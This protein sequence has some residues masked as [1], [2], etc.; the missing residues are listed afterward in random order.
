ME[1]L[2]KLLNEACIYRMSDESMDSFMGL[3]TEVELKNNE[4]LIPYGKFDDNIYVLKEGIMR[5][6]YFD[7]LKEMTFGFSSPG[8][9][10][11]QYHSFYKREPSFFQV[12]SCGRST[13]MKVSRADFERLAKSSSDFLNWMFRIS[14]LQLW[15]N[16]RKLAVLNGTA[17]E[18]FEALIR[19]RPDILK[20]VSSK[21]IASY[22]GVT[23][24][25]FSRLKRE[26]TIAEKSEKK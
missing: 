11:I 24:S 13:V 7:G 4:P 1:E 14:S 19:I 12:E 6:A 16:E 9:V 20:T 17:K 5:F 18:R 3:M 22:I 10:I 2:R 21:V 26:L 25:S 8:T 23:P 15:L